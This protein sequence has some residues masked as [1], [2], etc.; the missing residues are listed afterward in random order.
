MEKIK[1]ENKK[2]VIEIVIDD[3]GWSGWWG[4]KG[5]YY[6][7]YIKCR[8]KNIEQDVCND[9]KKMFES[10]IVYVQAKLVIEDVEKIVNVEKIITTDEKM[11]S[12]SL[13]IIN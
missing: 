9:V 6:E 7:E 2:I 1:L 11:D 12:R 10:E 8:L 13:K 5:D 4:K 3:V